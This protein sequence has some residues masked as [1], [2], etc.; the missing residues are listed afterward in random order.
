MT[1]KLITA[2]ASEPVTLVE[3]K[4]HLK[5]EHTADDDLITALI[6]TARQE[7]EHE[8]QR[9]LITQ[10]WERVLDFFPNDSTTNAIELAMP[11]VQSIASVK[12][13]DTAGVEQTLSSSLYSMDADPAPGWL[14]PAVN[15]VWPDTLDTA[16][17]V[18]VRFVCGYVAASDVPAAIKSWIKVRIGTL[19]KLRESVIVGTSVNEVP[20]HAIG[21]LLDRYRNYA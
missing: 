6:V 13:I 9:A 2:P 11:T 4:L 8:L 5:V 15:T 10:T 14:L 16:S 1:L 7:A 18:R 21:S 17:A 3:A 12:Y 19:Y 20:G